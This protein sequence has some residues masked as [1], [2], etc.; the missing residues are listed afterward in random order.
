[1]PV[2]FEDRMEYSHSGDRSFNLLRRPHEHCLSSHPH[3]GRQAP[4]NGHHLAFFARTCNRNHAT[5]AITTPNPT[6]GAA[7]DGDCPSI[8]LLRPH[9]ST[10]TSYRRYVHNS[11]VLVLAFPALPHPTPPIKLAALDYMFNRLATQ[12]PS[13]I[14][15]LAEIRAAKAAVESVESEWR[16]WWRQLA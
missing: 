7:R 2:L 1:M 8:S 12:P 16:W 10:S 9:I 14:D 4:L 6:S 5:T 11:P 3:C 13:V 15:R